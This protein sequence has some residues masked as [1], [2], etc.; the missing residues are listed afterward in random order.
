M[1]YLPASD[2]DPYPMVDRPVGLRQANESTD[3][4]PVEA[5]FIAPSP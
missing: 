1:G 5:L 2:D 3:V 4:L